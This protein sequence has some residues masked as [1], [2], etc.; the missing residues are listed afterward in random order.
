M[1]YLKCVDFSPALN[2]LL[3]ERA[4][5]PLSIF[6]PEGQ[7]PEPAESPYMENVEIVSKAVVS[8]AGYTLVSAPASS[9][10]LPTQDLV[11]YEK[12]S[13]NKYLVI[14]Q[15]N[16]YYYVT[17]SSSTWTSLGTIAN[18]VTR[19]GGLV[20]KSAA[21]TRK[22]ILG[23]DNSSNN[24]KIWDGT[25]YA[26]LGGSPPKG[27]I[28]D[29]YMGRLFIVN[30]VSAFYTGVDDE[31]AW[32]GGGSI[33]FNDYVTG[34]KAQTDS[35]VA[36]TR[37]K[38]NVI[39]IYL[40]D[41]FS[42]SGPIK[43]PYLISSGGIAQKSMTAVYNDLYKYTLDGVQRFGAD[44]NFIGQNLR[45]NSL[46]W[47]INPSITST[48]VNSAQVDGSCGVYFNKKYYLSLP[49]PN[50]TWN[51]KTWVY[52]WD[53]D[54]WSFRSGIYPSNYAIMSDAN[55]QDQ[56]YFASG[57]VGEL[58]KFDPNVYAYNSAGYNRVYKSK[59]FN[60]G[61]SIKFKEFQWIDVVGSIYTNSVLYVDINVDGTTKTFQINSNNLVSTTG[62]GFY[63]DSYYGNNYYG[64]V[65]SGLWQ[66][67]SVRLPIPQDIRQGRELQVT[68]RNSA[69]NQPWKID[70]YGINWNM[71][72]DAKIAQTAQNTTITN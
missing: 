18:A 60:F 15:N 4:I 16:T 35:M 36:D 63:G 39:Q 54:S 42:T 51:D 21:G 23:N 6:T 7:V 71:Y 10:T 68:F 44:A 29:T 65:G 64:G 22:L 43:K 38:T 57:I 24:T 59:R 33:G 13:T 69:V 28:M 37:R 62:G 47:K 72:D 46:S 25:T 52:N 50:T 32:D 55:N 48:A 45:V 5:M 49:S 30:G 1:P 40:S 56:L 9:P 70:Y 20:Y 61:N 17:N 11:S 34:L 19:A 2:T 31:T 3:D 26:D 41:S 8:S 67:F 14:L 27:W 12:D 58:Y 53:Y 66:R